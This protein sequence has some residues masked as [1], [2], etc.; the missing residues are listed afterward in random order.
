MLILF[1]MLFVAG[2]AATGSAQGYYPYPSYALLTAINAVQSL[3]VGDASQLQSW[4]RQGNFQPPNPVFTS[5][6]QVKA[7][8]AALTPP[9]RNAIATWISGGGRGGLYARN[10]TDQQIGPCKFP[11]DPASCTSG[12]ASPSPQNPDW[13]SIPFALAPGASPASNISIDGG[14]AVVRNDGTAETHCLTFRN[15]STKTATA[16]TFS[17]SLYGASDNMLSTVTNVRNGMFSSGITISGPTTFSDYTSNKN[18]VGNKD[19]LQNCWTTNS[20]IAN[21]AF[22]QATYTTIQ[23]TAVTYSDGTSWPAH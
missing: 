18:G 21:L 13:R 1:V 10:V 6:D 7:Q 11:I 19:A 2:S 4:V 20:G 3:S 22:L 17:F 23:V 9:D 14:F 12:S 8:I 16:V 5:L 15:T